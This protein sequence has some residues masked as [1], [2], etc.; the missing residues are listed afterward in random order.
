LQVR[1]RVRN[2]LAKGETLE[3][4]ISSCNERNKLQNPIIPS[5]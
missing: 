4:G 2:K 5:K 1:Q 3:P